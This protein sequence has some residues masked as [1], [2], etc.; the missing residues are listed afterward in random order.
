MTK[1][2]LILSV[3]AAVTVASVLIWKA[4]ATPLTGAG[5][6]FAVLKSY[7]TVHKAGCMFGTRRC[8]AGTKWVCV[9]PAP[10]QKSCICRP[11]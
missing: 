11:C 6:S 10:K 3:I 2:P 9:H 8:P 5:E 7:S 4:D 1:L